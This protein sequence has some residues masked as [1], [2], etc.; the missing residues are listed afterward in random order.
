MAGNA[1]QILAA[2]RGDGLGDLGIVERVDRRAI[3]NWNARQR[4]HQ[5]RKGR[6]PHAVARGCGDD[7]RQCQGLGRL[8]QRHHV[9]LQFTR[10]IVANPGHEADLVV[11]E[12][13]S[14]VFRC[15]RLVGAGFART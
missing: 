14:G 3:E 6:A 1:A 4:L 9:V 7:D 12:D 8:G 11:D 15:K 2:S 13:Q 5:F 10:R